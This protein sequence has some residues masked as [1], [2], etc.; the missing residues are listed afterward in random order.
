MIREVL[1][2]VRVIFFVI[3]SSFCGV[4]CDGGIFRW[5]R[6]KKISSYFWV[7]RVVVFVFPGFS[8]SW[9]FLFLVF[10]IPGFQSILLGFLWEFDQG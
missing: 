6:A 2:F 7:C 9:F 5:P 1:F 8:H 10:L 4:E 3:L